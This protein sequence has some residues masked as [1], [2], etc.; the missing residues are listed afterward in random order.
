M[1]TFFIMS[2]YF[3]TALLLKDYIKNRRL[4][5]R[6]FYIR[7]IL[8]L[9]PAYIIL[10]I[11]FLITVIFFLSNKEGHLKQLLAAFFYVSNWTRAFELNMPEYLGHTWSLAI[12]EQYYLIWPALFLVLLR[13]FG[14][15]YKI[16]LIVITL[17]AACSLWRYWLALSGASHF[18]LYNG[19][20]T[21][22]DSLLIGCALAIFLQ[23]PDV[24]STL[25]KARFLPWVAVPLLLFFFW[26]GFVIHWD[27]FRLYMYWQLIFALLSALL[28]LSLLTSSHTLAH[29]FLEFPPFVYCGKICY[30]LYLWHLPIF[31]IM[32]H[33][34]KLTT[35]WV[36]T[37]GVVLVFIFA[38]CSYH[39][40]EFRFLRAKGKYQ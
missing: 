23:L 21:R 3:I 9:F 16:L 10:Q 35:I 6:N 27:D 40:I 28:I 12:E 36:A 20:D 32:Y 22:A 18:R 17:A 25:K 13:R 19:F 33:D 30:S 38:C 37:V 39:F 8:R 14:L 34:I 29:K 4:N 26:L 1:D 31:M 7:R 11:V 15:S 2:A 24:C 5:L